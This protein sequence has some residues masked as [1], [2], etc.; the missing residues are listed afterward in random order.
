[1]ITTLQIKN[2]GI[3]DNIN[4]ELNEGLNVLTGETGAGKSLL[5]DALNILAGGR[6][7]KDMI[8]N[9]EEYS[10]I[11][12]NFFCPD[13]Y[14]ENEGNIIVSRE[15]HIS[16]KSYCKV[17]G[18]LV[19]VNDLKEF[20]KGIID[21]HGQHDNQN[22]LNIDKHIKY[23]DAFIG[24]E[25]VQDLKDYQ[26]DLKKYKELEEKLKNSY[27]DEQEKERRLDILNYQ[28]NEI[29]QAK[30]KE[31]EEEVLEEKRKI[32]KNSQKIRE[33]IASIKLELNENAINAISNSIRC[34]EK[35]LDC[36]DIYSEKLNILKSSYYDV[37][38]LARDFDELYDNTDF[39]NE[40][41]I[42]VE[43]RL[44]EIYSLKRKYGN[45][46]NEILKYKSNIEE[47]IK[48]IENLEQYHKDIKNN[49]QDLK[50][51]MIDKASKMNILRK[52]YGKV[53]NEK[54][55]RELVDLEM[56]NAKFEVKITEEEKFYSRGMCQVEF[57]I[58]TNI[59]DEMKPL[60]KIASGGEMSRVMLAIKHVLA[61]TDDVDTMVFDEIDTGISGKASTKVGKKMKEIGKQHQ[62][63]CITHLPSIAAMGDYNYYIS[64]KTKDNRTY[65]KIRKL[66]DDETINEIARIASGEVTEIAKAHARELRKI[67]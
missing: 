30:L 54:I 28:F 14:N 10:F 31:N 66:S 53:L 49:M 47:E 6:F 22:I 34:L 37:Q 33:N 63:I 20:M 21:I 65:T 24:K 67:S 50:E 44:D 41:T 19:T 5:I 17:N 56:Q 52:K 61:Q 2:F 59:G 40:E 60:T 11:E 32:I 57:Y 7:S 64:K 26:E 45:S 58:R 35:L 3:I 4:I 18:R 38:E 36:G 51:K 9:G 46:I 55:N 62:V 1:M 15:T 29:E 42:N 8:R 48:K 27:G 16:G 12:A 13:V 39:D 43:Q 23:L 25:I